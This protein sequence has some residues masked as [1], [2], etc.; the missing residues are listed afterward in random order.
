MARGAKAPVRHAGAEGDI[1]TLQPLPW[2]VDRAKWGS[3]H[4][5]P[6]VCAGG[7]R[8]RTRDQNKNQNQ[9]QNQDDSECQVLQP[10]VITETISLPPYGA[11]RGHKSPNGDYTASYENFG[12]RAPPYDVVSKSTFNCTDN[13][14]L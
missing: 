3:Q 10:D 8:G 11:C 1:K 5:A 12:D 2:S 13:Y 6:P 4:D 7:C 9:G 14:Q